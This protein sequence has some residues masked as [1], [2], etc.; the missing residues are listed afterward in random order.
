[1]QEKGVT[2]V[3][4]STVASAV[5]YVKQLPV[6]KMDQDD[7]FNISVKHTV[8]SRASSLSM[9]SQLLPGS[10]FAHCMASSLSIRLPATHEN[11]S[12]AVG[13]F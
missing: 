1:M 6:V 13:D 2:V 5:S 8:P 10:R 9:A 4:E 3:L 11:N 12:T 7:N